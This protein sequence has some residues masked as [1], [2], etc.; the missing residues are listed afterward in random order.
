MVYKKLIRGM[1]LHIGCEKK[2]AV[3]IYRRKD[4]L[5]DYLTVSAGRLVFVG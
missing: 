3:N 4:G 5:W 2:R 1:L